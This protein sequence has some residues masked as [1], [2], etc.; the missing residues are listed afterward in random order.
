MNLESLIKRYSVLLLMCMVSACCKPQEQHSSGPLREPHLAK[1]FFAASDGEDL[2]IKRWAP[3]KAKPQAVIIALHGFNDYSHAF[4]E[5]GE[6]L[7][8]RK[9]ALIAIDQRGFGAT[10][11]RGIWGGTDRM[12][13]DV[14]DMIAA[15]KSAYPETPVYLMGESMGGAVAIAALA[16]K[17]ADHVDGLILIAPAVWGQDTLNVFY[18]MTLWMAAHTFPAS[19]FTGEDLKIIATDNNEVLI[20]MSKDPLIVHSTRVDAIYGLVGL[21][22]RAYASIEK[23]N[24]PVLL[25]YGAK[26]EV[27]PAEPVVKAMYRVTS[28]LHAAYYPQGYHM[29]LRDLGRDVALGDLASWV[30]NP[31]AT[32]PSGHHQAWDA[33]TQSKTK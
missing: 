17:P 18:R 5:A 30:K 26:D 33:F 21:M 29:L 8:K 28:P 22:D 11:H 4:Q 2:P 12:L 14:N 15:T 7:A 32:L 16:E 9:I 24:V 19:E 25:L 6:F 31:S 23:L 10:A 20:R 3:S 1:D 13:D 27:I